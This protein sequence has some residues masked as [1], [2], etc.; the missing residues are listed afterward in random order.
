M[1]NGQVSCA[2]VLCGTR[3]FAEGAR[4]Q[5]YGAGFIGYELLG[6]R[7]NSAVL[8]RSFFVRSVVVDSVLY[9]AMVSHIFYD[10]MLV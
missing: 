5:V 1:Y 4:G 10:S 8:P 3:F 9:A 6:L 2:D 7:S